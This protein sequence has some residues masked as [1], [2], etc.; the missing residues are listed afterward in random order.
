MMIID[1]LKNLYLQKEREYVYLYLSLSAF[2]YKK[3]IYIYIYIYILIEF[4]Y[5]K[6]PLR[7]HREG[8]GA[9]VRVRRPG[10]LGIFS[11]YLAERVFQKVLSE[12]GEPKAKQRGN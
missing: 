6:V 5:G 1:V 8:Q 7:A 4:A 10:V 12:I 2:L 11:G 3:N 9:K